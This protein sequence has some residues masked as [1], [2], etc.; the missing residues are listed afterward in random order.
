MRTLSIKSIKRI[1]YGEVIVVLDLQ[2]FY[3]Y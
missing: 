2:Q 3:Y 1:F